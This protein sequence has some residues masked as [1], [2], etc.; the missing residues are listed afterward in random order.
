[1][2][3]VRYT[4]A[5]TRAPSPPITPMSMR[6]RAPRYA[7]NGHSE[8]AVRVMSAASCLAW[9]HPRAECSAAVSA[10]SVHVAAIST[11][12]PRSKTPRVYRPAQPARA[13]FLFPRRTRR[14]VRS[15]IER[16]AARGRITAAAT[17]RE[18]DDHAGAVLLDPSW[19]WRNSAGS[20][21]TL[22]SELRTWI[23]TS[24][25]PASTDPVIATAMTAGFVCRTRQT[26]KKTVSRSP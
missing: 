5:R 21:D 13:A 9:E 24:D 22:S 25:A 10:W 3:H 4:G 14:R 18:L 8:S 1:M 11:A 26:S 20:E 23:W 7:R 16:V 12:G 19:T 2:S 15:E 6:S 17:G